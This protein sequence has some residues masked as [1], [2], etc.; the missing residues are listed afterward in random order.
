MR[1]K[2][3]GLHV[4]GGG[5]GLSPL[6]NLGTWVA[7]GGLV[8]SEGDEF[9]PVCTVAAAS[10]GSSCGMD[11]ASKYTNLLHATKKALLVFRLPKP[12]IRSVDL[13]S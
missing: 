10:S 3:R 12:R 4:K 6:E 1:S 2:D 13:H 9:G 5:G 8:V 7:D 11:R